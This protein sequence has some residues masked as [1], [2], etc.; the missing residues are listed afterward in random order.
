MQSIASILEK[1]A[2]FV[3]IFNEA[4]HRNHQFGGYPNEQWVMYMTY[5]D[6]YMEHKWSCEK[7]IFTED[8]QVLENVNVWQKMLDIANKR[9]STVDFCFTSVDW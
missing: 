6:D 8:K 5:G 3:D 2:T 1:E 9:A 4:T 7:H